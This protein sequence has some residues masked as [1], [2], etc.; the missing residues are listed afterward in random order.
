MFEYIIQTMQ[1]TIQQIV[2]DIMI[3]TGVNETLALSLG[4]EAGFWS[5]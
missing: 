5:L 1:Q 3:T 4:E 2:R